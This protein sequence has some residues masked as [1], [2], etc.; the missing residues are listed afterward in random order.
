MK[1]LIELNALSDKSNVVEIGS[2]N[3]NFL[4][5]LQK[6]SGKVLGIDPASNVTAIANCSGIPTI[7]G[8]F[9]EDISTIISADFGDV[10]LLVA[11]HMFAHNS[12]AVELTKGVRSCMASDG[13]F[14]VENS[15]ASGTLVTGACDRV[16]HAHWDD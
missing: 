1:K 16:H 10:D 12:T 13:T 5:T 3:G 14:M 7:T 2:N 15:S 4:A 8:F 9:D 11:G 6:F